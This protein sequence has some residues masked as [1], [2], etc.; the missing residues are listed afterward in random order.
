M[1]CRVC[2]A[3]GKQVATFETSI[4]SESKLLRAASSLMSCPQCGL[5]HTELALDL[6]EYY[7]KHYDA[8][9]S[10]EGIDEIVSTTDGSVVFRTDLDYA[11]MQRFVGPLISKGSA[12][13]ELGCGR[14]RILSRLHKDGFRDLSAFDLSEDYR[15]GAAQFCGDRIYIGERPALE[16]DLAY[17][18]FVLEHDADPPDS[19]FY[20][21]SILRPSG[22]LF[23]MVP[24]YVTNVVDLA[25]ADHVNHFSGQY[26]SGLLRSLG[27][28]LIAVDEESAIGAV[29]VLARRGEDAPARDGW[30]FADPALVAY[31]ART[32]GAFIEYLRDLRRVV[33]RVS[34]DRPVYLYGAGFYATLWNAELEAA[35]IRVAGL[36][37]AN[38][39]K[40]GTTVLGHAVRSAASIPE[41]GL[42]DATLIVCVNPRIAPSIAEAYRAHFAEAHAVG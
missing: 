5:L 14:G 30:R 12:L 26:L 11:V 41:A 42:G 3:T 16:C 24:N 1:S 27:F 13:F 18:F 25:C 28:E 29:V 9:L 38:P 33:E 15:E 20:L 19:L 22:H 10:D 17:S 6:G 40:T 34:R 23:L 4:T 36:F 32:S 35:G 21:R 31:G 37:D 2:G 7:A 39:R 8:K